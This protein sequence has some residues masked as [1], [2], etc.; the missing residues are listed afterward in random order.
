MFAC[1]RLNTLRPD[2]PLRSTLRPWVRRRKSGP[3]HSLSSLRSGLDPRMRPTPSRPRPYDWP[4]QSFQAS[5]LETVQE[6]AL[7]TAAADGATE[8]AAMAEETAVAEGSR[9]S[10]GVVATGV[11]AAAPLLTSTAS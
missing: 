11:R 8:G 9:S 6:I 7:A 1:W 5:L 4:P 3:S 2:V 10:G